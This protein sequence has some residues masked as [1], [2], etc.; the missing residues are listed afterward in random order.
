MYIIY[1]AK[2]AVIKTPLECF[3]NLVDYP[4]APHYCDVGKAPQEL[5]MHYVDEGCKQ[6]PIILMLHGDPS[7]SYLYRHMIMPAVEQGFRV[8]V[9]DFIGFGKSDK[10]T[11]GSMYTYPNYIE[12]LSLFIDKLGIR[13]IHLI[14]HGFGGMIGFRL[15]ANEPQLFSKL[16]VANAFLPT[17]EEPLKESVKKWMTYSQTVD[18]FPISQT[19]Q[20]GSCHRI[21]DAELAAYDAPFPDE[22]YKIAPR[23][24]PAILPVSPSN[25]ES[26]K[27]KLAWVKLGYLSLPVLTIFGDADPINKGGDKVIQHRM[28]G[29][30]NREHAVIANASHFIQ[31]DASNELITRALTFFREI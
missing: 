27:N 13:N 29:S 2:L 26:V 6:A 21:S 20:H 10:L 9:P 1:G 25:S 5:L 3:D 11:D 14:C 16:V 18:P 4:F 22:S 31:E 23:R 17:G 12:W 30:Q 24:L 19:I 7:W 28:K 8:I 15:L